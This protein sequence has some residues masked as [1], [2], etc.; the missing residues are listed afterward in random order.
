MRWKIGL[1][2]FGAAA[3]SIHLPA[4]REIPQLEL[5]GICDS[6]PISG[7]GNVPVFGDVETMLARARP[8]ILAIVTPPE[9]HFDLARKGLEAGCHVFCEKPFVTS[10]EEADELI[11]LAGRR[12]RHVFVNNQFKFMNINVAAKQAMASDRFGRLVFASMSQTFFVSEATEAGWRGQD[13]QRTFKEFGSH[14]LDLARF[15]YDENP[16]AID[17]RMPKPGDGNGPDYLNLIQLQFSGDRVAQITLDRLCRGRHRYLDTRLDGEHAA[18]EI[19]IGGRMALSAGLHA[20]TRRPF[21]ALDFAFG[22]RTRLYRGEAFELLA[23]APRNIF[24]DATRRLM[25]AALDA[26]AREQPPPCSAEDNRHTLALMLAG[27]R[28]AQER[29][30][31][32][33]RT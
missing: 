5:V 3:R 33:M 32:D 24:A 28:S 1:I 23:R 15:F 14:V 26:I 18:I 19:S 17:A 12:N 10:L 25:E 7:A 29:R 4:Y 13:P 27:Y 20:P 30:S 2:G 22:G 6:R 31:I 16:T 8:D 21:V 11:A 9:S